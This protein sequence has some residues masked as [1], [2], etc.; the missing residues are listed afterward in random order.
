MQDFEKLGAFYLGRPYT[1]RRVPPGTTWSCTTRGISVT[2][3]VIIGMTGSGKTGLGIGLLEEAAIDGIPAIAIDPKGDLGNLLLTFPEL[4]PGIPPVDRRGRC[5]AEGPVAGAF[6]AE[7]AET[8]E[9]G[10][11]GLGTG[12]RAHRALRAAVGRRHLHAGQHAGHRRFDA[13]IVRAPPP[14][15]CDDDELLRERI[16]HG[17]AGLLTLVGVEADPLRSREHISSR[18]ARAP[19]GR[20]A[21]PRSRGAHRP[22]PEA[23]VRHASA[24]WTSRRSIPAKE[25]FE[26]AMRLNNL[27]AAPGFEAW[28][29]G[30]PLDIDR[31]LYTP[32]G[33]PRLSIVRSRT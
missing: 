24:C 2:H 4:A 32:A 29:E 16:E 20:P 33:K 19:H 6:A 15:V 12:R 11:G 23:A 13:A 25:R 17:V 14:E 1:W 10:S 27:L 30:E 9:E 31:L 7:Q 18:R 21:R 3:A 5:R 26:L 8:L 22:H 28:L